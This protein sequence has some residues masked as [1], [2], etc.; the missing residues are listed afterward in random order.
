[1]NAAAESCNPP[2][3]ASEKPRGAPLRWWVA[4]LVKFLALCATLAVIGGIVFG[5]TKVRVGVV[6]RTGSRARL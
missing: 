2:I 5:V 6:G 1:M 3:A 4:S